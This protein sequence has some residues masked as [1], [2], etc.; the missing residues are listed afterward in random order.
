MSLTFVITALWTAVLAIAAM[1]LRNLIHCALCLVGTLI[2]LA[3]IYLQLDAQFIAF[4]QM[5]VYVGAISVLVVFAM[6]LTK[7]SET[8]AEP[9]GNKAWAHGLGIASMVFLVLAASFSAST[10]GKAADP[11]PRELPVAALGQSLMTTHVLPLELI[12]LLLTSAM[13][14]AAVLALHDRPKNPGDP[15]PNP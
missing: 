5:L 4:S 14:G 6:L 10:V 9:R 11:G 15:R 3:V 12:A 13:I 2:G 1:T 7:S 8:Q